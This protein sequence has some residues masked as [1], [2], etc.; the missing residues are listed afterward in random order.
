MTRKISEERK[1]AYYAGLVLMVIGVLLFVSVFVTGAM[2]FGDFSDF[3]AQSRSGMFRA[4]GGMG[5]MVVGAIVRGIGARGLA[6]SGAV[7]D[8]EQARKDLEPF[9]RQ[10]GGMLGDALDEAGLKYDGKPE[11]VVML[12]CSACGKLSEEDAKFCRECGAKMG[13]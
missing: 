8:P 10:A 6:G 5:L 7:L 1:A 2:H 11:R 4:L 12:K 9:S 13:S 3:E